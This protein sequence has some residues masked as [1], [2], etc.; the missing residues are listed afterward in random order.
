MEPAVEIET[1][2]EP[3]ALVTKVNSK[4]QLHLPLGKTRKRKL[5]VEQTLKP[6]LKKVSKESP[7]FKR[8]TQELSNAKLTS[9]KQTYVLNEN[10]I[11]TIKKLVD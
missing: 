6:K 7:A 2:V 1:N 10:L 9:T 8:L 5:Q 11:V 4:K 3:S